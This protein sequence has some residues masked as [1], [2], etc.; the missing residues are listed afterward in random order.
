MKSKKLKPMAFILSVIMLLSMTVRVF[1]DDEVSVYLNNGKIQF[2]VK[3]VIENG[4]TLIPIRAVS[5]YMHYQVE[6]DQEKNMATITNG[7]QNLNI[8]IGEKLYT[9]DEIEKE[10]D[11][12]AKLINGRTLVPIRL[13]AES[14]GCNVEWDNETFS[15]YIETQTNET[16][17]Q[18]EFLWKP[19]FSDFSNGS[20]NNP[21]CA[22]LMYVGENIVKPA[23]YEFEYEYLEYQPSNEDDIKKLKI[24]SIKTIEG[25]DARYFIKKQIK[26]SDMDIC[27]PSENQ[28]WW[29]HKVIIEYVDGIGSLNINKLLN[30]ENLYI[31][32]GEKYE[33]NQSFIIYEKELFYDDCLL[34]V[35]KN[36]KNYTFYLCTLVNK[37]DKNPILRIL[38]SNGESAKYIHLN[39]YITRDYK[40]QLGIDNDDYNAPQSNNNNINTSNSNNS[41]LKI[42]QSERIR[43]VSEL[44]SALASN[45]GRESS[46][47]KVLRD[48]I[49]AIDKEISK[50]K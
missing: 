31:K 7:T 29:V 1:A 25:K 45:M 22:N 40:K 10:M 13:I 3:P 8:T 11:V 39:S 50:L 49:S 35:E 6:W 36:D 46:Y 23:G 38:C 28:T 15:I 16:E 43:L 18:N 37:S 27:E 12:P 30:S 24:K 5:E 17:E 19:D 14:F 48:R 4:R 33:T 2:D 32:T 9:E 20:I 26:K 44:N 42:L 47:T 41:N 21:F 34:E